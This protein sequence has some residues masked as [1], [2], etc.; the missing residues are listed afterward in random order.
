MSDRKD[1]FLLHTS[2]ESLPHHLLLF[3]VNDVAHACTCVPF[4]RPTCMQTIL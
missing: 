2:K 1:P 3:T 4:H